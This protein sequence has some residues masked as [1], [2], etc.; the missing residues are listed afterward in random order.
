MPENRPRF[1]SAEEKDGA[2]YRKMLIDH[3]LLFPLKSGGLRIGRLEIQIS[4]HRLFRIHAPINA[5]GQS[6]ENFSPAFAFARAAGWTGAVGAFKA[7]S[8]L[9]A[10]EAVLGKPAAF[11]LKI[12][13]R[14]HPHFIRLPKIP[15]PESLEIYPPAEK[16]EFLPQG[17]SFKEFEIL[18]VPQKE[19]EIQMPE[20]Q[21]SHLIRIKRLMS[22][23]PYPL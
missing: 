1:L 5:C 21:I 14:G 6:P 7:A 20:F 13:G 4:N 9:D 23:T 16:S 15:F 11:R 2:L 18:I 22:I 17:E 12:T 3:R 8:S 19:G 10:L